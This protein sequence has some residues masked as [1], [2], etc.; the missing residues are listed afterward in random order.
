MQ[1]RNNKS[2]VCKKESESPPWQSVR[3]YGW[4][5]SHLGGS[6]QMPCISA[7]ENQQNRFYYRFR[8]FLASLSPARLLFRSNNNE[9]TVY[10]HICLDDVN[11][12]W[13]DG[14]KA[15]RAALIYLNRFDHFI[16]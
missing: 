7:D 4:W 11:P 8:I 6:M 14:Q 3:R 5:L 15:N 9:K 13:D 10:A 16:L 2:L 1:R 12:H